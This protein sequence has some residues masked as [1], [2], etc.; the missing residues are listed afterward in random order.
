MDGLS[1][2]EPNVL[3]P[4]KAL[5][6]CEDIREDQLAALDRCLMTD[7][8]NKESLSRVE[9]RGSYYQYL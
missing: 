7:Q 5:A 8:V 9:E 4:S 1:V 2:D 3:F 6:D